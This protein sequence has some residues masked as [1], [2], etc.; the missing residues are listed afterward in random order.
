MT[1]PTPRRW[2]VDPDLNCHIK[3]NTSKRRRIKCPP[4]ADGFMEANLIARAVNAFDDLVDIA[5]GY[6]DYAQVKYDDADD[7]HR[8]MMRPGLELVNRALAKAKGEL[9]A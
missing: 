6:R 8:E 3:P 5:E 7:L 1:E 9:H 2:E 4:D